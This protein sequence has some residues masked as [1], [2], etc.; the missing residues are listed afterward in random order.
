MVRVSGLLL[1]GC[2]G[3]PGS[4][5][6]VG[7]LDVDLRA[8]A[9]WNG[10]TVDDVT[11]RQNAYHTVVRELGAVIANK[12]MAPG[13]T[14]GAYGFEI[15]ATGTVGFI[16]GVGGSAPSAWERVQ[17]EGRAQPALWMS[18]LSIRKGLPAS[19]DIGASMATLSSSR[20]TVFGAYG[21]W[22][23]LEGYRQ[24][25]DLTLQW[26]YSGLVGNDQLEAGAMDLTASSGYT[27]PFGRVVGVNHGTVTPYTGMGLLRIHARPLLSEDESLALGI[28]EISGFKDSEFYDESF[29][30]LQFHLGVRIVSSGFECVVAGTLA[31]QVLPTVNVGLGFSY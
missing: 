21:R 7:A 1:A 5:W 13:N 18:G 4:A 10:V 2:L 3:L 6:A 22:S 20:Q 31:R 17:E 26:G 29:Q 24:Y 25:P 15:K 12:P 30:P 28:S 9:T 27:I 23:P 16:S 14:L 8:L 19:V 11:I